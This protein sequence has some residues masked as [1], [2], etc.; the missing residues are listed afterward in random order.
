VANW[1]DRHCAAGNGQIPAVAALAWKVL[2]G[3]GHSTVTTT[4]P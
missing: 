1:L 3:P 4:T 2:G